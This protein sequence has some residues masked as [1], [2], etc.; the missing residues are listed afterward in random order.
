MGHSGHPAVPALQAFLLVNDDL[1]HS[2][3]LV[4]AVRLLLAGFSP[5]VL[6]IGLKNP[7]QQIEHVCMGI[8]C[9][10]KSNTSENT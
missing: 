7:A 2:Y 8:S 1:G 6:G 4:V 3:L 5:T 10:G 9:W